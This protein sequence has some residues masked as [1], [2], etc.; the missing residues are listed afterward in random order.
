M[1]NEP[2]DSLEDKPLDQ[3]FG[4]EV[5]SSQKKNIY[6]RR[7]E[8]ESVPPSAKARGKEKTDQTKIQDV[9]GSTIHV[10][11]ESDKEI[12]QIKPEQYQKIALSAYDTLAQN[13]GTYY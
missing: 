3:I 4:T 8:K 5:A 13:R 10:L 12:E 6:I 7:K 9:L 1:G 11:E 2:R